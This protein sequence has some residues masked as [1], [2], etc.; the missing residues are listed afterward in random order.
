MTLRGAEGHCI[1]LF[2]SSLKTT[3]V[4]SSRC[5]FSSDMR[6]NSKVHAVL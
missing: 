4:L 6:R 2:M 5:I 3:A 1:F